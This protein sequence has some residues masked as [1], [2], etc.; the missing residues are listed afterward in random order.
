ML[1][2]SAGFI[3]HIAGPL[4]TFSSSFRG[5][6]IVTVLIWPALFSSAMVV[7]SLLQSMTG[8]ISEVKQW[9]TCQSLCQLRNHVTYRWQHSLPAYSIA[10]L[11]TGAQAWALQLHCIWTVWKVACRSRSCPWPWHG[12]WEDGQPCL[13]ALLKTFA[14]GLECKI[15]YFINCKIIW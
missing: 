1:I 2:I 14:I 7:I 3:P 6:T 11:H 13:C 8:F 10:Y 12:P 9:R 4:I 15:W 5:S